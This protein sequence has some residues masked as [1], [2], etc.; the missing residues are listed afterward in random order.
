MKMDFRGVALSLLGFF[1]V[2]ASLGAA[3]DPT[4]LVAGATKRLD[5]VISTIRKTGNFSAVSADLEAS[6]AELESAH[7]AFLRSHRD[8]EASYALVRAGDCLR[9]LNRWAEAKQRYQ[10]AIEEA[11]RGRNVE[12]E[13]KA[14]LGLAKAESLGFQ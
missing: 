4:E 2:R 14:W 1:P 11:R 5:E 9:I 6:R 7:Q 3:P 13:A 10:T 8:A 12:F